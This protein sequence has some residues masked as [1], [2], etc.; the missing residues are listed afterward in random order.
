MRQARQDSRL[1]TSLD[2]LAAYPAPA[3]ME[4]RY[5]RRAPR[6]T[7][8]VILAFGIFV[9]FQAYSGAQSPDRG[10]GGESENSGER[11]DG[12]GSDR[13]GDTDESRREDDVEGRDHATIT[14]CQDITAPGH[15][16][17]ADNLT[18]VNTDI[19][20][21]CV[22]IHD[23]HD[24]HLDCKRHTIKG[25]ATDFAPAISVSHVDGFSISRCNLQ[26]AA[27]PVILA[28]DSTNGDVKH[29]TIGNLT[30][31][32]Q[33]YISFDSVH[34]TRLVKNNLYAS[35]QQFYS[36]D[37]LLRSN[38]AVCPIWTN[39]LGCSAVFV[40]NFGSRNTFVANSLDGRGTI[41]SPS[42][43]ADDGILLTDETDDLLANNIIRNT[44]DAGIETFGN[45]VR[46]RISSNS[47]INVG[48]A[49]I[50]A[51]Y[52]NSW[53]HVTVS[54]NAVRDAEYLFLLFRIGGLRPANWDG[55][56]IPPDRFVYF[57]GNRFLRNRF[58]GSAF[59]AEHAAYIPIYQSL[60]Y[61]GGTLF[62]GERI[63]EESD[64]KLG[65]NIF[66]GNDF[67]HFAAAPFFG[68]PAAAGKIVDGGGNRCSDPP[69]AAYPL[70]C[71]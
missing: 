53:Y 61:D 35:F 6:P 22:R 48:H 68:E 46:T 18:G 32:Q 70:A 12:E 41:G 57:Q 69:D 62:Q 65:G 14:A 56:G 3:A 54:D 31:Q 30:D 55:H 21:A 43:G 17:L 2:H 16:S 5:G 44:W 67:G 34:K 23:T 19:F 8:A 63:P 49:G 39:N 7:L 28:N 36:N 58:L 33:F 50:G 26:V 45:I 64:F 24:V 25:N 52:S 59:P 66:T 13:A 47:M 42:N 1:E 51:W 60:G 37:N 11:R 15:Y 20:T 40:S 71:Q 38:R 27:G 29:N 10:K 4:H 9:L